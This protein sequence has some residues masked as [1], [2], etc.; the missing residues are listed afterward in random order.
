MLCVLSGLP[1]VSGPVGTEH[2]A[3]FQH[4]L[5]LK[6]PVLVIVPGQDESASHPLGML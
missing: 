3:A 4:C 5:S 2:Q 1:A 6:G